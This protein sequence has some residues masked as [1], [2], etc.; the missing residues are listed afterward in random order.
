VADR[1]EYITINSVQ[2]ALDGAWRI[3]DPTPF[4]AEGRYRG[5]DRVVPGTAGAVKRARVLG[6]L[7][8]VAAMHVFGVKD[9][10]GTTYA[11]QRLGLRDNIAYLRGQ[12][13]P[14][15]GSNSVT[16]VHTFSDAATRSGTC[17]VNELRVASTF[18]FG[19]G[20]AA[21]VTLDVT[22]LEGKLT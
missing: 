8:V 16:I 7:G 13:L 1:D 6:P 18:E 21:V 20:K 22:V 5:R 12:L 3:I 2:L 10:T 15:Y 9:E 4:L 11:D 19:A 14:P 17:I